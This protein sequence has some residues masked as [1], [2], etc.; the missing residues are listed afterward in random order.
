MRGSAR[1]AGKYSRRLNFTRG[2]CTAGFLQ[3]YNYWYYTNPARHVQL[4][5]EDLEE[6]RKPSVMQGP[7][8][9]AERPNIRSPPSPAL[10][11]GEDSLACRPAYILYQRLVPLDSN[12]LEL[13]MLILII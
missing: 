3:G 2:A 4:V 5:S 9:P 1:N 13:A 10:T 7:S 6:L 12:F 8:L 11:H